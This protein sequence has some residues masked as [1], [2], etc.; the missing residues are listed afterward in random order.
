M[1]QGEMD[2]FPLRFIGFYW[3]CRTSEDN[4]FCNF[5]AG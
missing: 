2:R 5:V 3:H 4:E 1:L